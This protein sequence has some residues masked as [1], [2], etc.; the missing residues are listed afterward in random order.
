MEHVFPEVFDVTGG[1]AAPNAGSVLVNNSDGTLSWTT[2]TSPFDW[3]QSVIDRDLVTDPVSPTDGDRYIIAGVGGLWS[4]FTINDIVEWDGTEWD[5]YTPTEGSV[6]WLEDENIFVMYDGA[7]WE[8]FAT[9]I[10]SISDLDDVTVTTLGDNEVLLSASGVWINQTFAEADIATQTTVGGVV[11]VHSDVTNAGSGIIISDAERTALHPAVTTLTHT[12]LTGK[13]DEAD[14][15]HLTDSEQ[16][17]LHAIFAPAAVT[18]HSDVSD[19]GSGAIITTAERDAIDLLN[20]DG[21]IG[22]TY[23]EYVSA[24]DAVRLEDTNVDVGAEGVTDAGT[25]TEDIWFS[26][27]PPD[28]LKRL[29][30]TQSKTLT[31]TSVTLYLHTLFTN[32]YITQWWI[33]RIRWNS[34]GQTV[35]TSSTDIENGTTGA[36]TSVLGSSYSSNTWDAGSNNF[37]VRFSNVQSNANGVRYKGFAVTWTIGS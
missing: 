25:G 36:T 9:G 19:A 20:V 6:T 31:M 11:T 1:T 12:A 14:I 18:A 16:S 8:N 28:F 17:A 32:S 3:Q 5:N 34:T 26:L 37:I 15:K 33:Y 10:G 23:V 7:S 35:N 24:Q 2:T 21:L 13:N 22:S 29:K 30:I 4:T 27:D